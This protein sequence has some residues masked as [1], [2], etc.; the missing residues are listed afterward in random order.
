MSYL[1]SIEQNKTLIVSILILSLILIVGQWFQS[2]LFFNRND[3]NQGQWWKIFSGNFTH[4]NIPHLLLNLSGVWLLGILFIDS[5]NSISFILST[6]FLSL[7]VGLGL[8][9]F[10]PE[11]NGYYGFLAHFMACIS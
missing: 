9:L 4:S 2:D 1:K 6:T 5:L 10:N 11:L 3:I 7:V 8:Y